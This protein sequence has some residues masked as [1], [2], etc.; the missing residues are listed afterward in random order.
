M[1]DAPA[2]APLVLPDRVF[3][4][5]PA[6]MGVV[7]ASPESFSDGGDVVGVDAQVAQAERLLEAGATIIDVGG[8]S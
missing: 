3:D 6:I 1:H 8:E 2:I 7:N 5:W 4:R